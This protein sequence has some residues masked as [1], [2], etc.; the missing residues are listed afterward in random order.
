[1]IGLMLF[2]SCV[3]LFPIST[4]AASSDPRGQTL[5]E[6]IDEADS[7]LPSPAEVMGLDSS[8]VSQGEEST[9]SDPV[10]SIPEDLQVYVS[11]PAT[12]ANSGI[13]VMAV[14]GSVYSGTISTTY[15]D[16]FRG[17]LSHSPGTPYV[18]FR[19]DQYNYY[20]FYGKGLSVSGYTFTGS[21]KYVRYYTQTGLIYRGTDSINIYAENGFVY[22]NL[23]DDFPAFYEERGLLNEKT[24]LVALGVL[25]GLWVLNKL[26]FRRGTG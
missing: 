3:G 25:V 16:Y 13:S 20:M 12:A 24:I 5:G 14:S 8:S 9:I 4:S 2:A 6:L 18:V 17:I 7:V 11:D 15:L 26:F 1:M 19:S 23:S 10:D 22:S 21:G